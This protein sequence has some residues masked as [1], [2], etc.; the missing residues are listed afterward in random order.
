MDESTEDDYVLVSGPSLPAIP[1][2]P[3]SSVPSHL[4][5]ISTCIDRLSPKF[6]N[7]SLLIHDNPELNYKEYKAFALLV[8]FFK[9]LEGWQVEERACGVETAFIAVF[10]NR[11]TKETDV[12]EGEVVS[13]N[14]EYGELAL[15]QS[16]Y[17]AVAGRRPDCS[18]VRYNTDMRCVLDALP[19]IGHACGHNLIAIASIS[20]A[21][22]TKHVMQKCNI[23][24]KVV[25][26][27]TPAE[28]G[29]THHI[30]ISQQDQ[31]LIRRTQ[32]EAAR[33]NS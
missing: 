16:I 22:A 1:T 5:T 11:K 21:L 23:A 15:M 30:S 25:L 28:E 2:A 26:F 13:F 33:S 6:R 14:A 29:I 9:E 12:V 19:G 27:G 7:L 20:A 8:K 4:S 32:A 24:G 31:E 17:P 3:A 10:D 18:D